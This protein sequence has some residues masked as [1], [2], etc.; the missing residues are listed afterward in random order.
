MVKGEPKKFFTQ[1]TVLDGDP[2]PPRNRV[3]VERGE[4][5]WAQLSDYLI[6]FPS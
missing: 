4:T 2:K 3:D 1:L 6:D 5:S